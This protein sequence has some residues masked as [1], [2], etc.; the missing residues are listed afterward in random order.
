M[1]K[2]SIHF[3][4]TGGTI[5]SSYDPPTETSIPNETSVIPYYINDVIKPHFTASFETVFMKDSGDITDSMR[6][7]IVAG[8]KK[9]KAKHIIITHGTT[10]MAKT[11][12]FLKRNIKNPD[13]AVILTGAMIPLKEVA[14]SDGGFNLGYAVAA[15]RNLQPGIYLAMNGRVFKAGEAVKNIKKA[16]FEE[17]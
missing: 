1:K 15:A 5:D 13:K 3:I 14:L 17:K 8:I 7:K 9:S 10:M 11:A 2:P 16:R 6:R 4:I 12:A